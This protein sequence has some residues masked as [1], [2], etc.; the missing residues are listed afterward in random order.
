MNTTTHL[1]EENKR[2][3][4]C[5]KMVK[6]N[7]EVIERSSYEILDNEKSNTLL[8]DISSQIYNIN[9]KAHEVKKIMNV[10]YNL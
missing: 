4:K 3:I 9:Q 6:N 10:Y 1:L 7:I 5:L 8:S 2:L